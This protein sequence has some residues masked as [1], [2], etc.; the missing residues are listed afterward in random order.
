MINA[1]QSVQRRTL[2]D[3][4]NEKASRNNDYWLSS[5][6]AVPQNNRFCIIDTALI[7]RT[8]IIA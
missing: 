4:S 8:S 3:F 7:F 2:V 6:S 5:V 1:L